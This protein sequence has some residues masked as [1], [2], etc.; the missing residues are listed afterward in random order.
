MGWGLVLFLTALVE[1]VFFSLYEPGFLRLYVINTGQCLA[2]LWAWLLLRRLN[3]RDDSGNFWKLNEWGALLWLIGNLIYVTLQIGFAAETF[4]GPQDLFSLG[5][6]VLMFLSVY[7]LRG[8]PMTKGERLNTWLEMGNLLLATFVVGWVFRLQEAWVGIVKAPSAESIYPVVYPIFDV[9]LLWALS[10]RVRRQNSDTISG[11]ALVWLI[12]GVFALIMADFAFPNIIASPDLKGGGTVAD[13]GWGWY[14]LFLAAAALWQLRYLRARDALRR[15]LGPTAV[16]AT[17]PRSMIVMVTI[18][19]WLVIMVLLLL[20]EMFMPSGRLHPLLLTMGVLVVM[21]LV[22]I[23]QVREMLSNEELNRLVVRI[24]EDREQFRCFFMLFPN[25]AMLINPKDFTILEVNEGYTRIFGHSYEECIGATTVKLRM[26]VDLKLRDEFLTRILNTRQVVRFEGMAWTKSREQIPVELVGRIIELKGRDY[27]MTL[28]RDLSD[29]KA[30]EE[31]LRRSQAELHRAQK[32]E[33]IGSLAGGVAHDFN[34]LLT[35]IMGGTELALMDLPQGHPSHGQLER[36][37]GAS[38]QARDL[39]RQI[40]TFSRSQDR[41]KQEVH[42]VPVIDEALALLK[43]NQM[44]HVRVHHERR[45][46][47]CVMGDP[48]QLGQVFLNLFVNAIHAMKDRSPALLEIIEEPFR[49]DRAFAALHPGM[50]EG[51]YLHVSVR[52]TG[53]GMSE[54]VLEHLFE[55]FF[56][57]KPMGEGTGLGLA[58]VHGIVKHH[59]G[60]LIVHSVVDEGSIFHV[61]LPSCEA[62]KKDSAVVPSLVHGTGQ[63]VVCIDDDS[64]VLDILDSQL[65][66][67][68]YRARI[69][70]DPSAARAYLLSPASSHVR[71][72]FC[73]Y[74]MPQAD[75]ISMA[76]DIMAARSGLVW[77]LSSGFV[78]TE[79]LERAKAAGFTHFIDKPPSLDDLSAVFLKAGL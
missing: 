60:V 54:R 53:C 70:E 8:E 51:D 26:W 65:A 44:E 75:G 59:G 4:P 49:S 41:P 32:L 55:P 2:S 34:N 38:H 31:T 67:L 48:V 57:T 63:E 50:L 35:A 43:T 46:A 72:V 28:V 47:P 33:A 68:G 40:L 42:I 30:A 17:I 37:L 61:Y 64:L 52:D 14:S 45:P 62:S 29:E 15:S 73:D 71:V 20:R 23:R 22:I 27:M 69:F 25:A 78:T 11:G 18:Y 24:D 3:E 56:T 5:A 74:S 13:L 1:Y 58:V 6:Y 12:L 39:V 79:T 66:H 10:N 76:R 77:V 7:R 36:V 19:T 16:P 9:A 21:V